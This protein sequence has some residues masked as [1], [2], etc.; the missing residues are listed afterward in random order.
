MRILCIDYGSVRH[1]LA[2]SDLLGVTAQPLE[3]YTRKNDPEDLVFFKNLIEEK[4]IGRIVIGLPVNMDGSQAVHYQDVI[5]YKEMLE[6]ETGLTVDTWDERLTTAQ[7]ERI[8]ITADT[9]RK[10]RKKVVD[11]IASTIILQSYMDANP[12]V[13]EQIR[14]S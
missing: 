8:L 9:S 3:S 4:E 1:G 11:K 2:V 14:N 5:A 6:A 10:K 7:A 12:H 13:V